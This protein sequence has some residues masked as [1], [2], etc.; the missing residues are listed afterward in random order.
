MTLDDAIQGLNEG[1]I[2]ALRHRK[3]GA[4]H[5][6][7][8]PLAKHVVT[9]FRGMSAEE[10][11]ALARRFKELGSARLDAFARENAILAMKDSSQDLIREGPAAVA[12]GAGWAGLTDPKIALYTLYRSANRCGLDTPALFAEVCQLIPACSSTEFRSV[13]C[14]FL[15][16]DPE[17]TWGS[18]VAE[19]GFLVPPV[20]PTRERPGIGE[21][22]RRLT[23]R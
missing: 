10:R 1:P 13:I 6:S 3:Y 4:D 5:S 22:L 17:G 18:R 19:D 8:F 23:R 12:L 7:Y 9:V 14:D 16:S 20:I 11:D 2:Q 15:R 21:R